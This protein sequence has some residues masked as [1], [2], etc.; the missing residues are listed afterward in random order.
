MLAKFPPKNFVEEVRVGVWG[1]ECKNKPFRDS[2]LLGV[3]C[4]FPWC[5]R[6]EIA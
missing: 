5:R 6:L 3:V 4:I 1:V 2:G